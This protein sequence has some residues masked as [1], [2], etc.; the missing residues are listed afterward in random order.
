MRKVY[1]KPNLISEEFFPEV[2][3][4]SCA[5]KYYITDIIPICTRP[6]LNSNL[7]DGTEYGNNYTGSIE[8]TGR[9]H[10][11]CGNDGSDGKKGTL[12]YQ[13]GIF[14]GTEPNGRPIDWVLI[15]DVN[16]NGKN[17]SYS[18]IYSSTTEYEDLVPGNYYNATWHSTD[19]SNYEYIH[20]GPIYVSGGKWNLS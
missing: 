8:E 11:S 6:G 19:D 1:I 12:I 16:P 20:W 7:V 5:N 17:G 14:T 13:N 4:A 18:R 9:Y 10:G 15:G 2:Y 3:F